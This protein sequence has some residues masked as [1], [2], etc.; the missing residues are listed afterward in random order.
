[1]AVAVRALLIVVGVNVSTAFCVVKICM[2][3]L[4]IT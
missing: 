4:I 2:R 3:S 1:M